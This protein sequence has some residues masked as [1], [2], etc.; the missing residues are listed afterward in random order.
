MSASSTTTSAINSHSFAH[1]AQHVEDSIKAGPRTVVLSG[2]GRGIHSFVGSVARKHS[3]EMSYLFLNWY[4]TRRNLLDVVELA[5]LYAQERPQ[6]VHV[7][8]IGDVHAAS[9]E[10]IAELKAL[11]D[12]QSASLPANV[13]LVITSY[14]A[15]A[16]VL[17]DLDPILF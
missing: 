1:R 5:A 15:H 17:S 14:D 13:S 3:L 4:F 10:V 2:P 12:D 6:D 16:E 8:L 7:L 11:L 9:P